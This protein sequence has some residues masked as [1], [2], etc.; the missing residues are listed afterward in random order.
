MHTCIE[1]LLTALWHA[2]FQ[3]RYG[4]Y[5][6]AIILLA[7]IGL[8]F[9]MTKWCRR[10]IDEIMPQ[11]CYH[12]ARIYF[13]TLHDIFCCA[14]DHQWQRARTKSIGMFYSRKMYNSRWGRI[15]S[16]S[17]Q[18]M[19]CHHL[20]Q[21]ILVKPNLCENAFLTSY[22]PKRITLRFKSSARSRMC[23]TC[24]LLYITI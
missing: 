6:T 3:C 5:R 24:Y 11:V 19:T 9:G 7:D 18:P 10:L 20:T 2:E 22:L 1:Q 17:F 21:T 16:V 15:G 13:H 14:V 4:L 8:E 23:N 12:V